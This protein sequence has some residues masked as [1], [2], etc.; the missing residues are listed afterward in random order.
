MKKLERISIAVITFFVVVYAGYFGIYKEN[1]RNYINDEVVAIYANENIKVKDFRPLEII[2]KE[3]GMDIFLLEQF[4][5]YVKSVYFISKDD[6]SVG[7]TDVCAIVDTGFFYPVVRVCLN[8][9]FE[10][11]GNGFYML[12]TKYKKILAKKL[13]YK[14]FF[15]YSNRGNLLFSNRKQ[16]IES[17]LTGDR[18]IDPVMEEILNMEKNKN[19]GVFAL[20]LW[21]TK[22]LGFYK[23]FATGNVDEKNFIGEV[24]VEGDNR[25]LDTIHEKPLNTIPNMGSLRKNHLYISTGDIEE[26]NNYLKYFS[27][28]LEKNSIHSDFLKNINLNEVADT[29]DG[30]MYDIY[31]IEESKILKNQFLYGKFSFDGMKNSPKKQG[32]I[33]IKG[34]ASK[35]GFKLNG[36]INFLDLLQA[37]RNTRGGNDDKNIQY[38][39]RKVAG[40]QAS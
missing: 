1:P 16:E 13:G 15:M 5:K 33:E 27:Y 38:F 9:Y 25:L 23:I 18:Y 2:L 28:F 7:S 3:G 40:V 39:D 24:V 8:R 6:I 34:F 22:P 10:E 21:N 35:E 20:N 36:K 26:L 30:S 12:K 17:I 11:S 32:V 31:Q 37:V 4:L 19:L 29:N 14:E